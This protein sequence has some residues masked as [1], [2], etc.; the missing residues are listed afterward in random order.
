[1]FVVIRYCKY[2][3][4]IESIFNIVNWVRYA[5]L[6]SND[7][8]YPSYAYN[9]DCAISQSSRGRAS[10]SYVAYI[11]QPGVA[12]VDPVDP[13]MNQGFNIGNHYH[14]IRVALRFNIESSFPN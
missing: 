9:L 8:Q 13:Y 4:R 14:S 3:R 11:E 7:D 2:L 10:S 5:T 12:Y 1:M 6:C